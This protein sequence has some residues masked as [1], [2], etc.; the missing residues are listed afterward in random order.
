MK[1]DFGL[2]RY[3]T[4]LYGQKQNISAPQVHPA[5]TRGT[6]RQEAKADPPIKPLNLSALHLSTLSR[7]PLSLWSRLSPRRLAGGSRPSK[8]LR[9]LRIQSEGFIIAQCNYMR[10]FSKF[11]TRWVF[12]NNKYFRHVSQNETPNMVLSN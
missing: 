10:G 5:G 9:Q 4:L 2:Q 11:S 1:Q 12:R 7:G 3:I 6:P 8:S